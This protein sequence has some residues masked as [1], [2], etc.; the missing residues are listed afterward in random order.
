MSTLKVGDQVRLRKPLRPGPVK[1]IAIIP[2]GLRPHPEDIALWFGSSYPAGGSEYQATLRDRYIFKRLDSDGYVKLPSP[3]LVF[4]EREEEAGPSK[5]KPD[6]FALSCVPE[7]IE[8]RVDRIAIAL[9]REQGIESRQ[10]KAVVRLIAEIV[11]LNGLK[12]P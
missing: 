5:L 6:S 4:V 7:D 12:I 9:G 2:A 1:L 8:S 11:Q 3:L 10:V